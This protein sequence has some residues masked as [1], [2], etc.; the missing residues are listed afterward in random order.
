MCGELVCD[1]CG[2]DHLRR[3]QNMKSQTKQAAPAADSKPTSRN[4]S[5]DHRED[6][7]LQ[8]SSM[9]IQTCD[10]C[11]KATCLDPNCMV[12]SDFRLVHT[13]VTSNGSWDDAYRLPDLGDL[14]FGHSGGNRNTCRADSHTKLRRNISDVVVWAVVGWS[15]C[16]MWWH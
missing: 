9:G 11:G 16:K 8:I 5:G 15:L 10:E 2:E 6:T 7:H 13:I 1:D 14:F 4:D 3:L 12:C